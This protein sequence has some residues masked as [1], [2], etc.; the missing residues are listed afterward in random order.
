[1]VNQLPGVTH[2]YRRQ[3]QYNL[4]FTLTADSRQILENILK[5]LRGQTGINEFYSLPAQAVYKTNVVFRLTQDA[6][7]PEAAP[8]QTP[9]VAETLSARQK[10]LVRLLQQDLPLVQQPFA[11]IGSQLGWPASE[12]IGQIERWMDS[13]LIRRFGAIVNHRRLGFEGNGMAVFA[14]PSHEADDLGRRLAGYPEVT[15]CYRRPALPDW[16]YTLFAMVHGSSQEE[17]R[18]TV[19][20]IAVDLGLDDYTILFSTTEYKKTSMKYFMENTEMDCSS[21]EGFQK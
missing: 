1:L 3:H 12:V 16:H 19:S 10:E 20:R 6:P 15:H 17:V 9:L 14:V 8:Q 13:R 18:A 2:N 4:W 7:A 21:P 11:E 5:K